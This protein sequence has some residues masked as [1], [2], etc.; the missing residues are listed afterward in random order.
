MIFEETVFLLNKTEEIV[1]KYKKNK[2]ILKVIDL[3]AFGKASNFISTGKLSGVFKAF[4]I[5]FIIWVLLFSIIGM[6]SSLNIWQKLIA[7]GMIAIVL[8]VFTAP[9]TLPSTIMKQDIL[10]SDVKALRD[11]ISKKELNISKLHA[12]KENLSAIKTI[13]KSKLIISNWII[14]SLWAVYVYCFTKCFI[15]NVI[16][17]KPIKIHTL[18]AFCVYGIFFGI[19]YMIKMR[20][21][22]TGE[23]VFQTLLF[24]LNE[25][26]AEVKDEN[27]K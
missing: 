14:A 27:S 26:I 8:G 19:L 23:R 2:K 12:I 25:C 16:A 9:F 22:K 5:T 15:E 7:N 13:F 20:F 24:S 1:T 18:F 4:L 10:H 3:N 6:D 17:N 21:Q 11:E